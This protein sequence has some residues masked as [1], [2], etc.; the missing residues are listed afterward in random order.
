MS[1]N[2]TTLQTA[3][4]AALVR[5]QPPFTVTDGFFTTLYPEAIQYA[6]QRIETDLVLLA[7]RVQDV[8]LS[9]AASSRTID[10]TST[11]LVVVEG[12]AL[13]SPSGTRVPFDMATLDII[14]E[15]WPVQSLTVAPSLNDWSPR[16]WCLQDANTVVLCPTPDAI[17]TAALTGLIRMTAPVS[18]TDSNYLLQIYPSLYEAACM[19]FLTGAL[20]HNF[21]PQGDLPAQAMSW[22]AVYQ[23]LKTTALGEE[24]RRRGLIPDAA[25]P[26]QAAMAQ[27]AA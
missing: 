23:S 4:L 5:S 7:D 3:L 24:H 26:Q 22:E 15:I 16:F 9:T 11:G 27:R 1:L 17:Y 14:D 20:L 21:G 12:F 19:V 2:Y 10:I 18:G 25:P 6:Q 13:L 8:S